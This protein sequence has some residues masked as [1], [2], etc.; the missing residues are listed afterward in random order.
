MKALFVNL[1]N[2]DTFPILLPWTDSA[3][4]LEK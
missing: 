1:W 3:F 2:I 4:I